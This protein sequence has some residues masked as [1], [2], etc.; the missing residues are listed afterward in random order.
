MAIQYYDAIIIGAG[1]SGI[2]AAYHFQKRF[3]GKS[4]RILERRQQLGGTWDL[5]KYPGIRSDSDMYTFGFSFRPWNDDAAIAEKDKII[6]YLSDTAKEFGID[7]HF[8]FGVHIKSANWSSDDALWTLC[9]SKENGKQDAEY[10][11]QYIF[12]CV[13]YYDYD[14]GY[15]P[16]FKN[17]DD[18]QGELIHPQQWPQDTDYANKN[19]II[20]GSGA[21]AITLLPALTK[22][23]KHVTMVQRSPTYMGSKPAVDPIANWLA[24]WFGRF[25]ARW[26]FILN[27]MFIYGYSRLFPN[28]AKKAMIDGV[29]ELLS[30]NFDAKDF[31]PN[32]DPWDQRVCLV[33]DA[34]F[35]EAINQGK[36]N[37]ETDSIECFTRSGLLLKSGK[38]LQADTI[39]TATGLN[40]L[41]LGGIEIE[42][43]NQPLNPPDQYVYKGFMLS[44]TP[45]LYIAI[46]YTN[47]SWTLKVD[48]SNQYAC[49][50]I[51]Y[52][53]EHNYRYCNPRITGPMQDIP[54]LDL[55]SGY[56]Q[57]STHKL[58][59]QAS[60]AP[61][62]LHQN[63]ILDNLAFRFGNLKNDNL[64]FH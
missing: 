49:R 2:S 4:Y 42:V 23:A 64:K 15:T 21:T 61:W 14:H 10:S 28:S 17:I 62:R 36:A 46:G 19:I 16:E 38:E 60:R 22:K 33:P 35:F 12:M 26:W 54:L 39:V 43:D 9:T 63:F 25:A 32:Y 37:I 34:D 55:S 47:A 52:M 18:F 51:G 1:I 8:E 57:R 41:F 13:G 44:G 58:P 59:K 20:V 30:D 50:L 27:A 31:T 5:F 53:D 7:R 6:D 3:P 40:M 56:I 29:E 48:L 11:A 24:K 45:N